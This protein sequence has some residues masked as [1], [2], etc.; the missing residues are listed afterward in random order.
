MTSCRHR[1]KHR[2]QGMALVAALFL[3]VLLAGLAL[4]ATRIGNSQQ[5]AVSLQ[6]LALRA[7]AAAESGLEVATQRALVSGAC[8][9]RT[10]SLTQAALSGFSVSIGCTTHTHLLN[11][12]SYPVYELTA[13]AQQ[14]VYGR[15]DYVFRRA[16]RSVTTAP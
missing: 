5:Q 15:P 16:T 6:I 12:T 3:M 13:S 10:L 14:G 7:Q 1:M 2:Q 9:N 8:L 4:T 11:G